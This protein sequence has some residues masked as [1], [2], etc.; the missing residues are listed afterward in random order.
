MRGDL[1]SGTV[2][3][4]FS[5]V[6]G[7]T[8]LLEELGAEAY[9]EALAGHRRV[10][11]EACAAGGGVEVDTQGDAF[12]Y[13]FPTAAGAVGAAAA[14]TDGLAPGPIRVRIGVH[15]GA[16]LLTDEGYVGHDV[17]R[18]ARVA[19]AGHGGQVLVS[20]STAAL[21]GLGATPLRDLGLHRLKDL[22]APERIYQS[23]EGEFPPLK[24]LYRTN[25]PVPTTPFF[26]RE[27]E[28]REVAGLIAQEDV[29]LVTL[30]GPGGAGKTR[31]ALQVAA[32]ASDEYPDGV[33]WV[34]LA[35][36]RDP[37]LAL[38]EVAS[39][40]GA[41]GPV[42]EHIADRR[43]LLLLDNFEHLAEGSPLLAGLL[44]VCRNLKVLVTSRELLA[45][46]AERAYPVP[47]LEPED[48]IELFCARARA[49]D[50][51][52]T[53]DASVPELCRR[54]DDL[55]L[56]LEL[57]AARV[58]VLS[59]AQ[60]LARLSRR[61]DL[62]KGGR[63]A[64]PRQQT[65]RAT[66]EWSHDLLQGEERRLFARLA[67][68]RGGC[69]LESAEEVCGADLDLL[70]SLVDKS[71]VRRTNERFWMLET[72]REYALERLEVL[73]EAE[74]LKVRHA[75]HFLALVESAPGAADSH[76]LSANVADMS[77]WRRQV[78]ADF[79]NVRAALAWYRS[80]GDVAS[81]LRVAFVVAWLYLWQRGGSAE[82]AR[83]FES[84]LERA[85]ELSPEARVDALQSL[86]HFDRRSWEQRRDLA[87]QSLALARSIGDDGRIEWSLRRL[88]NIWIERDPR[89]AR[90]ILLECEPLARRL[91]EQGRLAWIQQN[92]GLLALLDGDYA[93]ARMR[94]EESVGLFEQL[95]GEWQ[96]LN[97]LDALA[98]V[99]VAE[100]RTSEVRPI[101][102]DCLPRAVA[103]DALATV[104][105]C[106]VLA[107]AVALADRA[108]EPAARLL[109]AAAALRERECIEPERAEA[110]LLAQTERA[111]RERLGEEFDVA[112]AEG[113]GLALAEAVALALGTDR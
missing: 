84:V 72:I 91:P 66:I 111:V 30:T 87:E 102:A 6:E 36:L 89:T 76:A 40:L 99:L 112:F 8:H 113:A 108:P 57:A 27:R 14:A 51:S 86:A 67:V 68:F 82:A 97:A 48:G 75:E 29:R 13:V 12:F 78:A 92:V 96:S 3:F 61:L 15:T 63:D 20:A 55:P 2:T 95:G 4:L 41:K 110:E 85:N 19:A 58:S 64:D 60:L 21:L 74:E 37:E 17:H 98:T 49:A 31:L 38:T 50:P 16:P 10:L 24:S 59:P 101:L 33:Y 79:E 71:L 45:I 5:D 44:A 52:F 94:L 70:Q 23:G 56:A 73:G 11:R 54:L 28:L 109:G 22:S 106:L 100:G 90:T 35:S 18:A 47:P 7:S 42:A 34:P 81:E 88:G 53:P 26:G 46:A 9:A 107:A 103:I 25:L 93:D 104:G 69:T 62:F 43:L 32:E 83:W 80:S 105:D 77:T 1:P 39:A 65:L